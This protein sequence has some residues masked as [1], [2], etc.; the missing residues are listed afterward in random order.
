MEDSE[1]TLLA[2]IHKETQNLGK[3]VRELVA[4]KEADGTW[5]TTAD[6][7]FTA[8]EGAMKIRGFMPAGM[9]DDKEAKKF[10]LARAMFAVATGDWSKAQL[11]KSMGEECKR[12]LSTDVDSK[13]GYI[14]PMIAQPRVIEKLRPQSII[15][16]LGVTELGDVGGSP[17]VFPKETGVPTIAEYAENGAISFS[18]PSWGEVTMEPKMLAGGVVSSRRLAGMANPALLPMLERRLASEL[19]LRLDYL[20]FKGTGSSNQP[21]GIANHAIGSVAIGTNGGPLTYAHL[22]DLEGTLEDLFALKGRLGFAFHGKIRRKLAKLMD[23]DNR[24]LFNRDVAGGSLPVRTLI[25]YPYAVGMQLPTNLTKAAGVSLAEVYFGNFEDA[26]LAY[27]GPLVLEQTIEATVNSSSAFEKHQMAV[28][29]VQDFDF[30]LART[31]SF[32]MISDAET[33]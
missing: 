9:E 8:I 7:R 2:E 28:K 25:G 6:K 24:P 29:V 4:Y 19:A 16:G 26:I 11:E 14:V 31:D 17:I 21:L 20:C 10:N 23:G 13:G 22:I 30:R 18:D 12:T 5:K 33:A 32:A 1:K 27:F 15:F 3:N